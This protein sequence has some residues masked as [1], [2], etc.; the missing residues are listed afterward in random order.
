LTELVDA[1]LGPTRVPT[2]VHTNIHQVTDRVA[3][4]LVAD[5]SDGITVVRDYD[6]SVPEANIDAD[7]LVQAL[8]NLARN[9]IQA[10]DGTGTLTL[11]TRIERQVTIGCTRHRQV[12]CIDVADTG[13]GIDAALREQIF[14]PLVTTRANGSGLGLP[15]AQALVMRQDGIIDCTSEPGDTVFT[16]RV[17]IEEA[18]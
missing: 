15:I 4:L 13:P 12:A 18:K 8:L 6:P 7:Q 10:M 17:P 16:V 2:R 14:F 5:L 1:M 11:R 9:G 3:R